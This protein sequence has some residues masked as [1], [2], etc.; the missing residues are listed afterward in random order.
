MDWAEEDGR[1]APRPRPAQPKKAE[2][3]EQ[4]P[5]AKPAEPR[6][7]RQPA[8]R[9]AQSPSRAV[10]AHPPL[11]A[12]AR[13]VRRRAS[14]RPREGPPTAPRA[15]P[16][17]G[18]SRPVR[19]GLRRRRA[20][21]H[22]VRARRAAR[23]AS[24]QEGEPRHERT[25]IPREGQ[26]FH[27]VQV[28]RRA[29]PRRAAQRGR[30]RDPRCRAAILPGEAAPARARSQPPREVPPRDHERNGRD[31]FSRRDPRR[32]R[33]RRGQLRHLRPDR[34]RGGAGRFRLPQRVLRAVLAGDVSDLRLR[35]R[36]TEGKI[37]AEAAQ[38]RV[39]RLLRPHR[40]RRRLRSRLDAHARQEGGGRLSC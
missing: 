39:R 30:A 24:D 28:G 16:P 3:R 31:G 23:G 35:L 11:R 17:R 20:R 25:G 13:G 4:A 26:P 7:G 12:R 27:A 10:E 19:H 36:G 6:N 1:Q 40:T 38:R 9:A 15:A 2:P 18:G 32:L 29:A 8:G 33:L 34:A 37:P 22:A 5:P 14:V 21:L